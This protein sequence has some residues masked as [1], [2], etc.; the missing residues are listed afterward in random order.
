MQ[1]VGI[2][3]PA[4]LFALF[5]L[6]IN[7]INYKKEKIDGGGFFMW[8]TIWCSFIF[9]TIFPKILSPLVAPLNLFRILDLM[10]LIAF[11]V[12]SLL[13]FDN[14]IRNREIER[15][16]EKIVRKDALQKQKNEKK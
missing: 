15:K 14:Y 6:Y 9:L 8:T 13:G 2:Q 7:F 4:V 11:A 5:M 10:M 12:L 1:L 3:I 16:I